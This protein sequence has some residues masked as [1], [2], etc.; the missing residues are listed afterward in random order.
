[1]VGGSRREKGGVRGPKHRQHT[2]TVGSHRIKLSISI[3]I[4]INNQIPLQYW[5][6]SESSLVLKLVVNN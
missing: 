3:L 5:N 4:T 6:R 2:C 1:M